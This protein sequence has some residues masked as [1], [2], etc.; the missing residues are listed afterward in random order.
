MVDLQGRVAVVTGAS[1]GIGL[2]IAQ[3]LVDAGAK[4]CLTARKQEALDAAVA[5]LG[6]PEHAIAVAGKG[7]DVE[8]QADAIART[9]AAFGPVDVLVNNA[10]IN[11][12]YGPMIDI[13]LDAAR[14]IVEVNALGALSWTQ[15]AYRA[16]MDQ[17]G[18]AVVNVAS[19]AGLRPAPG[20]SM[21]GASKAMLIHLTEVLAV[22]LGPDVRVNAVAP[23]VVKTKFAEALYAGR[24]D[25]VASAYPLKRLGVPDDIGSVVAF[26]ASSDSAW[27]TGQTLVVDGGVTLTGGV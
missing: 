22:E 15:Q 16:G 17:H 11:P 2:G 26:L 23:A 24:E 25:E 18:G 9:A 19:V 14:K 13:D 21:Y 1:R 8:H 5:E 7:D 4:V 20:I 3:R 10:G 12:V 27:M 6:G